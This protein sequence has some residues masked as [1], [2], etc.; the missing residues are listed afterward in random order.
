M[1][2]SGIFTELFSPQQ[3]LQ[4]S[5]VWLYLVVGRIVALAFGKPTTQLLLFKAKG[6]VRELRAALYYLTRDV[7]L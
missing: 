7:I 1:R 5:S 6:S 2:D 4:Q 3:T